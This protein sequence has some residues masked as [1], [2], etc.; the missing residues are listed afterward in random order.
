MD[1]RMSRLNAHQN[2]LDRYLRLLE[3]HLTETERQY[4]E[5]RLSEERFAIAMLDF[6]SPPKGHDAP[7]V[8][9]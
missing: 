2:N 4:I 6:L 5:K 7:R 1:E 8:H 3:T 9:K